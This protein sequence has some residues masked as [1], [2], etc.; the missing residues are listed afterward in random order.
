VA[1]AGGLAVDAGVHGD[2]GR[3]HSGR[4]RAVSQETLFRAEAGAP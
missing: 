3:V 1:A 4:G 2:L